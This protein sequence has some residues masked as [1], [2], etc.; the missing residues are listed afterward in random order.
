M[1][2][3][4]TKYENHSPSTIAK[5]EAPRS[6]AS[7]AVDVFEGE[8][9]YL[10]YADVPGAQREDV[11]IQYVDGELR[12]SATRRLADEIG[13]PTNFRRVFTVGRDVD[14]DKIE[15]ELK[16]GVL[17]VHVPKLESARPKSIAIRGD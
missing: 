9:E 4:I 10:V 12:L 13:W 1:T 6:W 14:V 5:T 16:D 3:A 7:A 15:A 8:T 17:L 11:D 2:T